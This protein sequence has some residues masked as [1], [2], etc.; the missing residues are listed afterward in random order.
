METMIC[1]LDCEK[2]MVDQE[3]NRYVSEKALAKNKVTDWRDVWK[4]VDASPKVGKYLR[5]FGAQRYVT[6]GRFPW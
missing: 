1:A 4:S 5:T 6:Q 2:F 3:V